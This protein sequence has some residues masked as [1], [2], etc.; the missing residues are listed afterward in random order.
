MCGIYKL[1]IASNEIIEYQYYI[2]MCR[3]VGDAG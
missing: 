3:G 2:P 1:P